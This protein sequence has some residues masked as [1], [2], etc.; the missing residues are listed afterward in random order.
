M[1]GGFLSS[2]WRKAFGR[3]SSNAG[4]RPVKRRSRLAVESLEDRRLMAAGLVAAYAFNEGSGTTLLDSSGNGNNGTIS[5]ATWTTAGKYGGALSFNGTNSL[6]SVA[7]APSLNLTNGM[8]LEAWVKPTSLNSADQ[9]WDAL[10]SR[11]PPLPSL[12]RAGS[13][14]SNLVGRIT[15]TGAKDRTRALLRGLGWPPTERNSS[16]AMRRP[17]ASPDA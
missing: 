13:E 6:V 10:P 3:G 16:R 17:A 11:L 8:T 5:N 15:R 7:N 4:R 14:V 1:S 12:D 2:W 9:G